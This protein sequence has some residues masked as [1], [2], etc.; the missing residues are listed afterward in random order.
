MGF[1]RRGSVVIACGAGVD[2]GDAGHLEWLAHSVPGF[3]YRCR[4][5]ADWTMLLITTGVEELTEYPAEDFILNRRRSYNSVIHHE[6]REPV[7]QGVADAVRRGESFYLRYRIV[8]RSETVKWV[9]EKGRMSGRRDEDTWL[10]GYIIDSTELQR[11]RRA[12][13]ARREAMVRQQSAL[14]AIATTASLADGEIEATSKF[15]TEL[16]TRAANVA[17][18]SVWLLDTAKAQLSLIDLYQSR[19][20]RHESRSNLAAAEHPEYFTALESGRVIDAHDARADPRT[21]TFFSKYLEPL[22]ITSMLDAAIRVGGDVVGV[23]C[24]QHVGAPRRW[25]DHEVQFAGAMADQIS[26]AFTNRDR[27]RSQKE[28]EALRERLFR[29]QK[30]EAL[31]RLAGGVAH[32]FNNLLAV[33]QGYAE[34]L[35]LDLEDSRAREDAHEI[36]QAAQQAT[37]LTGHLLAFARKEASTLSR[38]D[39]RASLNSLR[40]TL[41]GMAGDGVRLK[42]IIPSQSV[43]VQA[44]DGMLQQLLG[45]LV[46]NARDS[47]SA[48]GEIEVSLERTVLLEPKPTE[49]N[50]LPPGEYACLRVSDTGLGM[51]E[52]VRRQIFEPFFTTKSQGQGAGLGLSIVYG[53]VERCRGGVGV[54]SAPGK[55]TSFSVYLP[56]LDEVPAS[57]TEPPTEP[58]GEGFGADHSAVIVEDNRAVLELTRRLL[59]GWGFHVRSALGTRAALEELQLWKA[60]RRAESPPLS[61]ILSD[62]VM[63]EGGGRRIL[64]W[65]RENMPQ[66][67][68]AFITGFLDDASERELEGTPRLRKPF[69]SAELRHLVRRVMRKP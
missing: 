3:S 31:G 12:E 46:L 58:V 55:G 39:L 10:D 52:S 28:R 42:M 15:A 8:T 68:L 50:V 36:M 63:P 57:E 56:A 40:N 47:I 13:E 35:M 69:S 5:D 49:V 23:V 11:L 9:L 48:D 64:A 66:V 29:S 30:L 43:F 33:I 25:L 61:L 54:E 2:I 27:I 21:S 51:A 6:D 17:R 41:Q 18:A 1:K 59:E 37:E 67:P 16:M 45:N 26:H 62:V 65:A 34:Q 4:M 24:L 53:I 44:S 20:D 14:A 22:G 32:D 19:E 7:A 60:G 38:V